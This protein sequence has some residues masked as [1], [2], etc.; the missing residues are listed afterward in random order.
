MVDQ[1]GG[2]GA[3]ALRDRGQAGA[4]HALTAEE[5]EG[6]VDHRPAP[7]DAPLLH[8]PLDPGHGAQPAVAGAVVSN[9][10]GPARKSRGADA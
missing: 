5:F 3:G 1:G 7:F 6:G 4:A 10:R 8:L 9:S 2:G